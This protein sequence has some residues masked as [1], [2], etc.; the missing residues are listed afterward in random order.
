ME[1]K[2]QRTDEKIRQQFVILDHIARAV[3]MRGHIYEQRNV[4][5]TERSGESVSEQYSSF[6]AVLQTL[7]VAQTF[8]IQF[9][10]KSP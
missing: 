4:M 2:I 6:D 3:L 7:P 8:T 9:R 5:L 1:T 10:G